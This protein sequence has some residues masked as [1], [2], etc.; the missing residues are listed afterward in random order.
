MGN[1]ATFVPNLKSNS[2][3]SIQRGTYVPFSDSAAASGSGR[4]VTKAAFVGSLKLQPGEVD[5]VLQTLA[6][7]GAAPTANMP[8]DMSF[9]ALLREFEGT[10]LASDVPDASQ[11]VD[12]SPSD[13][14]TFGQGLVSVRRQALQRLQ[15]PNS[16]T[17]TAATPAV[18]SAESVGLAL[19]LLNSAVVQG[20]SF[21]SN[22]G[23]SQVGMLNLERLEMT[24]AG[25]EQGGLIATVP[26][27]P[28]EVTFVV[29]KEW[30][31]TTQEFTSIVTDSLDNF[32][33]T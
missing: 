33:E 7:P 3:T 31:V 21:A 26:L 14:T 27:A 24:P 17:P 20:K 16:G 15:N 11:F 28:L 13:L 5:A 10:P 22:M 29:Q 1:A 12:V 19:D 25:I 9:W 2:T 6:P 32:S 30:S 23:S 8:H 18:A 4:A